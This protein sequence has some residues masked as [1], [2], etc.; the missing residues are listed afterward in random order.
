MVDA[1]EVTYSLENGGNDEGDYVEEEEKDTR[2]LEDILSE[3]QTQTGVL[4]GAKN[5]SSSSSA[6]SSNAQGK[7]PQA[8]AGGRQNLTEAVKRSQEART[9]QLKGIRGRLDIISDQLES[10][11]E[12]MGAAQKNSIATMAREQ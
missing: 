8:A 1:G 11:P 5:K 10:L 12:K 7:N 9:S 2:T 4:K 3:L 6:S